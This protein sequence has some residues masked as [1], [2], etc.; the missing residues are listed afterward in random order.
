MSQVLNSNH[1]AGSKITSEPRP[2][3][4]IL[5]KMLKSNSPLAQGYRK[6]LAAKFNAEKGEKENG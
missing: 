2:I 3:G 5:R 4:A 6:F 1:Q